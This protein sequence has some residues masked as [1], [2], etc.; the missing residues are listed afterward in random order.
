MLSAQSTAGTTWNG[1]WVLRSNGVKAMQRF[2]IGSAA[3]VCLGGLILL[4]YTSPWTGFG[5]ALDADGKTVPG[6][7]LWDWLDLFIV[8][9]ALAVGAWIL[10]S[11]RKESEIR[12]ELDRQHQGTLE[13]YVTRISSLMLEKKFEAP[14]GNHARRV[15]RTWTLLALRS[16]DGSRKAQ[17]LQFLYEAQLIIAPPVI[18][19][20]GADLCDADLEEA[21]LQGASLRGVYLKRAR[22]RGAVLREADLRGSDFS[23][24]NFSGANLD[25]ANLGQANLETSNATEDQLRTAVLDQAQLPCT[26]CAKQHD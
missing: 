12:V 6:K 10:D 17:L 4:G 24:A 8:P 13:E 25:Q 5:S 19:L 15:A 9:V 20:N 11:S 23:A 1:A 22:L 26:W 3:V 21:F 7:T 16:L 14:A 2:L 18:D